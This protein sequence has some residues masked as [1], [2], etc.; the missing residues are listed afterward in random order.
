MDEAQAISTIDWRARVSALDQGSRSGSETIRD[1]LLKP[2][3]G[4][5]AKFFSEA[6][7]RELERA[8]AASAS[9][10]LPID[11]R[12]TVPFFW[13]R[14]F[15]TFLAGPEQRSEER[16]KSERA[17]HAIGSFANVCIFVFLLTLFVPALI[18]LVHIFAAAG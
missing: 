17:K 8:L 6:Q 4:E 13:R 9:R 15:V 7:L 1:R 14:Y 12:I 3:D 11:V 10:R 18:G 16:L 2:M 5:V